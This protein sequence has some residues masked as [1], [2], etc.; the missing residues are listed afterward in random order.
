MLSVAGAQ[1]PVAKQPSE[2]SRLYY[3][4]AY[5]PEEEQLL[6]QAMRDLSLSHKR[7]EA[8][9]QLKEGGYIVVEVQYGETLVVCLIPPSLLYADNT[10]IL[11]NA[12]LALSQYPLQQPVRWSDLSEEA[13][14]AVLLLLETQ[15]PYNAEQ[16]QWV[17]D[18]FDQVEISLKYRITLTDKEQNP[19]G[20]YDP[21]NQRSVKIPAEVLQWRAI[22]ARPQLAQVRRRSERGVELLS[23]PVN[24]NRLE[25][26]R[27]RV[28]EPA[29][30]QLRERNRRAYQEVLEAYLKPCRE[31]IENMVGKKV[32]ARALDEAWLTQRSREIDDR[33]LLEVRE[34]LYFCLKRPAFPQEGARYVTDCNFI[35]I[36]AIGRDRSP[37]DYAMR[38]RQFFRSGV[39]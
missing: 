38:L 36:E 28:Y 4:T 20:A 32:E 19:V 5:S 30:A 23:V 15:M 1:S 37:G 22:G 31:G 6:Q 39:W 29:V 35:G 13:Q 3:G 34:N 8:I 16:R 14:Q 21:P 27:K 33:E 7:D 25:Q 10:L 12:L 26:L 9:Q 24:L 11:M 2:H 18:H 17:I